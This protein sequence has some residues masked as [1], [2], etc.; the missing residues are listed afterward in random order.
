MYSFSQTITIQFNDIN[1]NEP[2]IHARIEMDDGRKFMTDV[3]GR[4]VIPCK[5]SDFPLSGTGFGVGYNSMRFSFEFNGFE[6]VYYTSFIPK[7][8]TTQNV[9][10]SASRREQNIKEV[11]VSMEVLST[12]QITN[13]G[14]TSL[15][16][17]VDQS[18]G[19]FAM[20]GQVSIRGGGGYAYGAGSRVLLV[21]NGIPMMSP[22]IGDAK[23][24]SIPVEQTEQIEVMKGASSVLYGSG[25]LNG[26]ISLVEREPS[27]EGDL[28]LRY[29]SGFYNKPRRKELTWWSRAP[30]QNLFDVYYGKSHK[31][32]GYSAAVHSML[33]EGYKQG[34]KENRFRLNGSFYY[35]L[36]AKNRVKTGLSYN[37]QYEDIGIFVL[38]KGANDALI[39]LDNTLSN[40]RSIRLNV[41]PYLFFFDKK[42][43]K[44]HF[45]NRYYLV[46]TGSLGNLYSSSKAEM[47]YSDY[48]FSRKLKKSGNITAGLTNNLNVVTSS[49]FGNHNSQNTAAY[50]KWDFKLK[51]IDL[52]VGTRLE[53]MRQDDFIPDSRFS[54]GSFESPIYPIF[55]GAMHYQAA[56]FSHFRSSFGQGIRFPSVAERF[57]STSVGGLIIFNNPDLKP[58]TGWTGEVGWKQIIPLDL[59]EDLWTLFADASIFI[60]EYSNMTEFTFGLYIPDSIPLS[61]NPD[62]IGYFGNWIGFQAQNA[63][64]ARITGFELSLS[65][66]GRLNNNTHLETLIGYTYMNPVSLNQD[67]TYRSTF[68]NPETNMLKYRFNHLFKADIELKHKKWG[69]GFSSRYNSFMTNVDKIFETALFGQELLPGLKDYREKYNKG[70]FVF[71]TRIIYSINEKISANFIINNLF[72]AEY[73]SR[74]GDIQPP[75]TFLFQLRFGID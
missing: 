61:I 50:A 68:S 3:Q 66:K 25:A 39:P 22:D 6:K 18:P 63:E 12:A 53:Y 74:P 37:F 30:V 36:G 11:P 31:K 70:V 58:E 45:R 33:N 29:Q 15:D 28:K 27:R 2:I 60:N 62:E 40:Q 32:F 56:K 65:S 4:I 24:N 1:T 7:E 67:S 75:R 16:Q 46:T 44:H 35:K 17:I 72:N 48:Q 52:T 73:V 64:R 20:D 71:D 69:F 43:N 5:I 38:W 34:E 23:W 47:Y 14:Y 55:R 49:V 10:V 41:D 51:K 54:I 19:V 26:T 42:E 13:K 9:V 8:K 59:D 57:V 21:W